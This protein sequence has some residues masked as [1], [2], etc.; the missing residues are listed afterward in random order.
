[1]RLRRQS[2]LVPDKKRL[3][4]TADLAGRKPPVSRLRFVRFVSSEAPAQSS[5]PSRPRQLEPAR[6]REI[7]P[8]GVASSMLAPVFQHGV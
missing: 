2:A 8:N 3:L 5:E 6:V 4:V 7:L 1:M